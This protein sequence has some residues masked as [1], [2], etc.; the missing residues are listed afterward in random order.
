MFLN[1][2][3]TSVVLGNASNVLVSSILER[4]SHVFQNL[5]LFRCGITKTGESLVQVDKQLDNIRPALQ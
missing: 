3:T 4:Q 2:F 1:V 5:H